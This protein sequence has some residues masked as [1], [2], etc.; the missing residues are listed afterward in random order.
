MISM[1]RTVSRLLLFVK[2]VA[3]P[4][5]HGQVVWTYPHFPTVNSPV[6]IYYDASKGNGA[7]ANFT[8]DIY[9]H[10]G[11]ITTLSTSGTDW[12]HVV[13]T[14]G[15]ANPAWKLTP[16]GGNVYAYHISNISTF[17]GILPSEVVLK[18]AM[19]FRNANGSL[20]GRN[21][22]GSD[23]F[24]DVWDGVTLQIKFLKP[25]QSPLFVNLSSSVSVVC[26]T[27]LKSTISVYAGGNLTGQ[28]SNVDSFAV[29]VVA[30]TYGVTWLTAHAA[31]GSA[32]VVDSAYVVVNPPIQSAN[33]PNGCDD[34]VNYV[35]DS[36]VTLVLVAPGKQFVY[37]IGDFSGWLVQE[38]YYMHRTP[39]GSRWWVTIGGLQP[40][41]EYGYQ[42]L[43]D[44]TLYVADP[45]SR[46]VLDPWHDK[47][48]SSSTYPNLKPYP[49][50][51]TS[52]IVSVFQPGKPSYN[53]QVPV[54]QRPDPD[55]LVIYELLIR[56]FIAARNFQTLLDTLT[57]LKR[58]G[59]TAIELMPFSEFEGND[60]W[61]YNPSFYFAT[62][63]YYGPADAVK[64]FIDACHQNG[65][66]VIQDIVLNHAFSQSPFCQLYWDPVQFWPTAD[67]PWLN[68]DC[69]PSAAGYQ[70]KHPFGVG[71]DFNH[72]SA[73]TQKLVDDVL[74]Y[75]VSEFKVDGFRF[76]L[77]KGF[78]QKYSGND[79]GL[80]GQY[81]QSRIDLLKRMADQ[82]RQV[83]PE[84][85]LILEHFADNSEE[86][87]LSD[88][89][90]YLWGNL[91]YAYA[92]SAMGYA[93]G[94][95]IS[96]INYHSRGWSQ[97]H[98]VGYMESHDEERLMY[99]TITFGNSTAT[100]SVKPLD[101]ALN[102]MK[103][104][105]LLFVLV[106]GPK[107]IWQ[108]GEL[109]Y[110]YSINYGGSNVAAKPIRWDYYQYGPR[111]WL[112]QFYKALIEFKN[113]HAVARTTQ[114]T[115]VGNGLKKNLRLY[116]DTLNVVILGN[117]DVTDGMQYPY[118]PHGGWWYEYFTGDSL[119]VTDLNATLFLKAGAYRMYTDKRLP[120]PD[121]GNVGMTEVPAPTQTYLCVFP[122]PVFTTAVIDFY[123][124]RSGRVRLEL[125]DMHGRRLRTLA[126]RSFASGWYTMTFPADDLPDGHY[127]L[128]LRADGFR[129]EEGIVVQGSH[130]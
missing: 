87:V 47:F 116:G 16:L 63:K 86:K 84:V 46:K 111:R 126:D 74:R 28:S 85:I 114:F 82:I 102:R 7:L 106:P 124:P 127:Q 88:Y 10:T 129:A 109:G 115:L 30:N 89:G 2:L 120:Q 52:G 37:V 107:M 40:M 29:D 33:V 101:S 76:D 122:N 62:D 119:Y 68:S 75:W 81:D 43:V 32:A 61:G 5:A 14:W 59:V 39:D 42:F 55:N 105:A 22:D 49:T 60:S 64:A 58:L 34:G 71:Y 97:P 26:V 6:T 77:S 1:L 95:D 45:Y 123:V 94:S 35:N 17:Y 112:Y 78:T 38:Q 104:A 98:V 4:S 54:F 31:L 13:T 79:V 65:I 70:G 96:W 83:D 91:N 50:G 103:L 99:K 24:A 18:L 130:R 80:W 67:N 117:F 100:Y 51:K 41:V 73:Y 125:L 27:S 20:V 72:E 19:V 44:G 53:W 90:F 108:F 15:V 113:K 110:D 118:F 121:L 3:I 25:A 48:I 92:Q 128:V 66:A 93:S 8:G 36:T 11:V 69:N 56:D 23:I 12:K 9:I 21:S 57:Y